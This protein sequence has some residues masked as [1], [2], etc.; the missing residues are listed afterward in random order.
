MLIK[1]GSENDR[2]TAIKNLPV[3]KKWIHKIQKQT[4]KNRN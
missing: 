2:N 1:Q 3:T 4:L